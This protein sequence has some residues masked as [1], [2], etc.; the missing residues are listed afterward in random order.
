MN[1]QRANRSD[2]VAVVAQ[3]TGVSRRD[4]A[5]VL[6]AVPGAVSTL[7]GAGVRQITWSGFVSL[8]LATVPAHIHFDVHDRSVHMV[9]EHVVVRSQVT[10]SL[11]DRVRDVDTDPIGG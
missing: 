1:G 6:R 2:L 3:S 8:R 11:A 9:D 10:Q 7:F 4:V 5:A